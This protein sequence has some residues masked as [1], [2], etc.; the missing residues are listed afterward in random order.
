[1]SAD[2]GDHNELLAVC[3]QCVRREFLLSTDPARLL[4]NNCLATI[5]PAEPAPTINVRFLLGLGVIK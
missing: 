5:V 3:G 1:M 2:V 4:F